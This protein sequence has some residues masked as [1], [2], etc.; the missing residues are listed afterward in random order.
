METKVIFTRRGVP[1][2]RTEKE[3]P[4]IPPN[5]S[6]EKVAALFDL[7]Q[8]FAGWERPLEEL[9][10]LFDQASQ[11]WVE[12]YHQRYQAEME[13]LVEYYRKPFFK[14]LWCWLQG[15][16]PNPSSYLYLYTKADILALYILLL[17]DFERW[18][19]NENLTRFYDGTFT[20][21]IPKCCALQQALL[22]EKIKLFE[23]EKK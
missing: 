15:E 23:R 8:G 3:I 5:T 19:R 21:I 10:A 14:R 11:E 9:V 6:R 4:P 20:E 22:E 17:D 16:K 2:W 18:M 1:V 12:F 7:W 13:A